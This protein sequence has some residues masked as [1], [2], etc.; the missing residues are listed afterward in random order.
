[1][2]GAM[3]SEESRLFARA[4]APP[5]GSRHNI[6]NADGNVARHA[7]GGGWSRKGENIRDPVFPTVSEVEGLDLGV[8]EN[9]YDHFSLRRTLKSQ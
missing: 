1:M 2:E 7:R 6:A 4:Y 8:G 3:E 9:R 5:M